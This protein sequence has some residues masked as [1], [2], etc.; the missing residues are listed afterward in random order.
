VR[1]ELVVA[2]AVAVA[3]C[4]P[5]RTLTR[6]E[7]NG[8][9]TPERRA[10][11]LARSAERAHVDLAPV[12]AP[13][14]APDTPLGL[15]DVVQ[16]ASV[17]SR[18]LAEADQDVAIAAARVGEARGRLFPQLSAQGRYSW[19]TDPQ[20][21]GVQ[22]PPSAL[23]ALGGHPPTVVVREKDFGTVDGTATLPIDL[24][25][26]ITKGLTAAQ[27]G[28]RAEEARRFA[29]LLGEQVDAVQSYFQLLEAERLRDVGEQTL[30]AQ[31]QQ[32]TNAQ[33]RVEAGRL[34]RNELL[35][36]Q[37]AVQQ[38]EQ[39]LL[40]RNLRIAQARWKLNAVIGRPIDAPTRVADVSARPALPSTADAL[41]DA[42]AH[43]PVLLALVEEQQRLEDTASALSR[44]RLPSFQ[45]GGTVDYNTS[46]IVQPQEVEG[47]FVGFT[48]NY[49]LGGRK[50]SQIAQARIAADQNRTRIE[51]SLRE[52]ET[53]VRATRQAAEERLA[54]L[55]SAETAVRQAEE[56]VR[57]RQQQFDVGRATS[58]D[59][60]DAQALLTQQRATLASSLYQAHT[61]R[62][63]LQQVMGLPVDAIIPDAEARQRV[64]PP[65]R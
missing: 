33:S 5:V 59:L 42:Y 24:F 41:R 12:E 3:A 4:G 13:P 54:A 43:N 61:R 8:G 39:D 55:A 40:L 2:M 32:L 35:V 48:W 44:S 17:E 56:N 9:W 7:G 47:A 53:A 50:N 1:A 29:T 14:P 37:V 38:T 16:L 65:A 18:R 21:T 62:A 58:E 27:A 11:E 36:V 28:Y 6:A 45:G 22:L 52:V 49:D 25:G 64:P 23:A 60:L 46:G 19:Y 26:E 34:T 10:D 63:E 31:R 51:R 57:I 30:A 20:T 15:A